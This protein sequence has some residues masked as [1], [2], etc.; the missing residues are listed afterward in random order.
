MVLAST[1]IST[2]LKMASALVFPVK[3]RLRMAE[4]GKDKPY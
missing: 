3:D 2:D 1:G 4:T